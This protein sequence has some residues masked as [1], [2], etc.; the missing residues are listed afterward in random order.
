MIEKTKKE[1]KKMRVLHLVL[2]SP[3]PYYDV[4]IN[5]TRE[6]YKQ[7]EQHVDTW[8]YFCDPLVNEP[9]FDAETRMFKLPGSETY[10]PGILN[11][12]IA[13]IEYFFITNKKGYDFLVRSNAS[14]VINFP[15]L[16]SLIE[17]VITNRS[18]FFGSTLCWE[19]DS[20]H[21]IAPNIR[22]AHGTCMLFHPFAIDFLL[23][24]K[25]LLIQNAE[26]DVAISLLFTQTKDEHKNVFVP[27]QLGLQFMGL[28]LN[29]NLSTI[30]AFRNH[31]LNS[32]RLLDVANVTR[33]TNALQKHHQLRTTQQRSIVKV[34][35][36]DKLDITKF[37]IVLCKFAS[38]WTSDN[39][40]NKLDELFGD[41]SPGIGK[42][43]QITF[44]DNTVFAQGATLVF[45]MRDKDLIVR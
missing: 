38:S 16:L 44:H 20:A 8:Y 14:T 36:G 27:R 30:S 9:T 3:A 29:Y 35:Y 5:V 42:G 19:L 37:I 13:A 41:P 22:L 18:L 21:N 24:R 10:I 25:E 40:N 11:K 26:D 43:L 39:N 32:D 28:N 33:T 1:K 7:F 2:Y 12:T 15:T 23:Q 4:M 34:T 17:N 6:W 31:H 45:S